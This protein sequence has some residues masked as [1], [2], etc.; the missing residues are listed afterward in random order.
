MRNLSSRESYGGNGN[1]KGS[2]FIES[3]KFESLSEDT[4]NYISYA[5]SNILGTIR[6]LIAMEWAKVNEN[7][8]RYDHATELVELFRAAGLK[9]KHV[10]VVNNQYSGDV[11]YYK[12]PWV[13]VTTEK[14]PLKI[15]W[16]KRV[17]NLDWSESDIKSN[18]E[19][20][21]SEEKTTKGDRYVHCWGYNKAA[22]YI[23][24]L[25]T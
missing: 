24:K 17:I 18:G 13:I 1:F 22:E 25:I 23:K 14:G 8:K 4:Q 20:L 15:G 21:F 3:E 12:Y 5:A 9:I 19:V 10:E 16:R 11:F 2:I 6:E 7:D